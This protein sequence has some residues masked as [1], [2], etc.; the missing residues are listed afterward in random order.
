MR[1]SNYKAEIERSRIEA[2]RR[3]AENLVLGDVTRSRYQ[4]PPADTEH[5]LEYAYYLLPELRGKRVLD[6][7]CGAGE[8]TVILALRGARV[9]GLDISADLISLAKKR[10]AAN[11]V[12]AD[13]VIASAT[14]TAFLDC[15][16][17]VVFG[18]AI[19]HHL[20]I[21]QAGREAKRILKPGGCAIFVEPV[22]ESKFAHI[23]RRFF[24][25]KGEDISPDEY[26]LSEA[27]I[28]SFAQGM[29][30][31]VCKPY[32]LPHLK[33][34]RA[35]WFS[36]LDRWLL[37]RQPW[38]THF[39]RK[40]VFKCIKPASP[41]SESVNDAPHCYSQRSVPLDPSNAR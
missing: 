16:F 7:G 25:A 29:T 12:S 11:G 20:D 4:A 39:A 10:A 19:L 22:R 41:A 9:I 38:L 24:P 2:Q 1:S 33:F 32:S 36:K 18:S 40:R 21:E 8:N 26:P 34:C 30:S 31:F 15:S 35:K 6:F 5:P 27:N 37:D 23:Y 13:F 14:T 3:T 28:R 17:D